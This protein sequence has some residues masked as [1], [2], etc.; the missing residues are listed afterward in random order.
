[1]IKLKGNDFLKSVSV[2]LSGTVIS[3]VINYVFTPL[4][5]RIYSAE[6]MGELNLYLRIIGFIIGLSTARFELSLPLPKKESHS[7]LLYRLS[8]RIALVVLAVTAVAGITYIAIN[9]ITWYNL[10]FLLFILAGTFFTVMTN[11]GTNW[12]IRNNAFKLIS[13]NRIINSSV[14]SLLKLSFG[15]LHLGSIGLILGTVIAYM[16]SSFRFITEYLRNKKFYRNQYSKA[17]QRVLVKEYKQFPT[18]NLPHV[19]SDLGRD[20]MIAF[21]V[22]FYYGKDT[23]GLY[24][25]SVMILS[26][27]ITLIGTSIGQ[28][29]FNRISKMVNDNQ[30]IYSLVQKTFLSLF[31]LALIP[32]GILY[33]FSED[34]FAFAFGEEWRMAGV[35]AEIMVFYNF[36]NFLVSPMSHLSMVL[37]RQKE[38]FC[39]ALTHSGG[40]IIILGLLPLILGKTQAD[41]IQIL[42]I[43]AAFQSGMM[44]ITAL[45]NF[46]YAKAGRKELRTVLK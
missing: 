40:Q 21:L 24:S 19:L 39:I 18:I 3:Q 35:Y 28:V 12:A 32:F 14:S 23:F 29:F 7:F 22:V 27:P 10:L 37:N 6:E 43:L 41:F 34:I 11:L 8:V 36:F 33:L 44:L 16:V 42:W 45:L 26:V 5:T 4:L 17:K 20:L 31:A 1:M 15:W 13:T 2:L 30:S 46:K 9:P 25:Y 38:Y